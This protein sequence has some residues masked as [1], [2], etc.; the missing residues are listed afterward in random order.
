MKK[1]ANE[2]KCFFPKIPR[3]MCHI[4]QDE[5]IYISVRCWSCLDKKYDLD[6][7]RALLDLRWTMQFARYPTVPKMLQKRTRPLISKSQTTEPH[8]FIMLTK[9]ISLERDRCGRF[10]Y[11]FSGLCSSM[12]GMAEVYLKVFIPPLELQ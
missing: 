2:P 8:F 12:W 4:K 7:K 1:P 5:N 10:A 6:G 9:K 3:Q 11:H